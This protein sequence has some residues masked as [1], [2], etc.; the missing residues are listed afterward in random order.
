MLVRVKAKIMKI[1]KSLS[2]KVLASVSAMELVQQGRNSSTD[3]IVDNNNEQVVAA[4]KM[5][6][7]QFG[8]KIGVKGN[9]N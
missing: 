2:K 9:M 1:H 8:L 7:G 4:E 3:D 6:S 5:S